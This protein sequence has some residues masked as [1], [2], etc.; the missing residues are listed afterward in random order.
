MFPSKRLFPVLSQKQKLLEFCHTTKRVPWKCCL[1]IPLYIIRLILL[2]LPF[3]P[4][5]DWSHVAV[6]VQ[7]DI[8]KSQYVH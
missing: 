6:E 8:H 1:G 3:D 7:W 5:A 4:F 2:F